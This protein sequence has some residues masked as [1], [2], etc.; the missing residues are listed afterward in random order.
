VFELP[1]SA[2]LCVWARAVLHGTADPEH[3]GHVVTGDDDPHGFALV[4]MGGE[5]GT[6]VGGDS[7]LAGPGGLWA[8]LARQDVDTLR[9]SLPAPGD[10][11]GL[12]GP[13]RF[14]VKA[15]EAGEA[16]LAEGPSGAWGIVPDVET[17]GSPFESG[18]RVTWRVEPV[19]RLRVTDFGSV[20]EA[21]VRLRT[22]LREATEE[23][24]RLDLSTWAGDPSTRLQGLRDGGLAD[25]VLPPSLSPRS[26]RVI[27]TALR[28][29]A[30]V[31]LARE[32]DGGSVTLTQAGV[33]HRTLTDLDGVS[34][35]ALVAAI[36]EPPP[37]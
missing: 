31:E 9:V 11:L 23:L 1:R 8:F 2:L 6:D 35:R 32:D 3:A 17:Y 14:N 7:R 21:D 19:E 20:G 5:A 33:R 22:A 37:E 10:P 13:A 29:R 18:T 26:V 25:G 16:V 4:T 27:A 24:S 15:L 30:I 34:R 36:N 28:I 12:P